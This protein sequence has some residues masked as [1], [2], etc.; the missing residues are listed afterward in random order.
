M[1]L[2]EGS[3]V[4][5]EERLPNAQSS[6]YLYTLVVFSVLY[7]WSSPRAR[8]NIGFVNARI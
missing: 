3:H 5:L 1:R 2:R 7:K 6:C 8:K 4:F